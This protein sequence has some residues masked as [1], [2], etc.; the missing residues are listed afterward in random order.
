[1][2]TGKFEEEDISS[3]RQ[4]KANKQNAQHS[5]GPRTENGK[6]RVALNAL[7]HGLTG[8]QIVLPHEDRR[9]AI[10]FGTAC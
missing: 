8:K 4:I 1:M 9:T 2:L 7:K 10:F 6:A 5:T 3:D